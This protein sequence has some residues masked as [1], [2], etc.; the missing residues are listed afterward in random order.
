MPLGKLSKLLE[1]SRDEGLENLERIAK[2]ESAAHGLTKEDL[3]RYFA[4]NLHFKLGRGEQLGLRTFHEKCQ[5]QGLAPLASSP[6]T[7]SC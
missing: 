5:S 3:F 2:E 6:I 7:E 1:E 4:E